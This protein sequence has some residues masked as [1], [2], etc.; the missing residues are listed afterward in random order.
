[1]AIVIAGVTGRPGIVLAVGL[2]LALL[3]YL[4]AALFPLSDVLE[5]WAWLSPWDW[6]LGGDPL[7]NPTEWARY[8]A[9]AASTVVLLLMGLLAFARRDVRSA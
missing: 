7:S 9:L 2:G 6:A 8:A 5:D 1:V 3:G 4:V